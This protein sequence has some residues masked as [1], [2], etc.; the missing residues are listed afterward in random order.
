MF[1]MNPVEL[2]LLFNRRKAAKINN[3]GARENIKTR[4]FIPNGM[5]TKNKKLFILVL[6]F[7]K[8]SYSCPH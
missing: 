6:H 2:W 3:A 8:L 4:L 7:N 1:A 5:E